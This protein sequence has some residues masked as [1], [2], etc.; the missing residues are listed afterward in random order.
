MRGHKF[1]GNKV[2]KK[3]ETNTRTCI[4]KS[5]ENSPIKLIHAVHDG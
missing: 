1:W 4:P 3:K 2:I 5:K